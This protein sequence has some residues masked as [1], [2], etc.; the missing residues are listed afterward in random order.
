M[1]DISILI[2]SRNEEF[3]SH[4]IDDILKNIEADTEVI[5]TLDG[6]W[7]NPPVKQNE[8]VNSSRSFI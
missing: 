4:T 3:L 2:P 8:R 1:T 5:V 6:Q 7:P